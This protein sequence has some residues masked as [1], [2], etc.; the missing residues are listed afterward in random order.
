MRFA[1]CSTAAAMLLAIAKTAS[2]G[3]TPMAREPTLIPAEPLGLAIRTLAK[4]RGFQVVYD[5]GQVTHR[6]TQGASGDLTANEALTEVLRGT[7]LT[8]HKVSNGIVIEP[9]TAHS[10][11]ALPRP[12]ATAHSAPPPAK[13]K[14]SHASPADLGPVTI[15]AARG[16][17]ALR[18]EVDHF[19][20]A[21]VA[22]PSDDGLYRWDRLVCP[23]VAGFPKSAGEFIL[24]RI[25]KAAVDAHAPLAGKVCRPNLYVVSTDS[26][27]QLLESWWARDRQMYDFSLMG[28]EAVKYFIRSRRPI[29]VWY[30]TFRTCWGGFG[31]SPA[32]VGPLRIRPGCAPDTYLVRRG[33]SSNIS[34][35]IVVIDSRRI[36]GMTIQQLADYVALVGLANLR[37]EGGPTPVPSILELFGAGT[38]PKGLTLWDRALLYS[39]YNTSPWQQLQM[40]ELEL[41]MAR[42]IARWPVA[43]SPPQQ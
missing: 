30:N 37:L 33:T 34:S 12:A 31:D 19:A 39:L 22:R 29:R 9:V 32:F 6:R 2:A 38:P 42:Y 14:P 43:W 21:V 24:E 27:D 13:E 40:P 23:L 26:P 10:H 41:T 36:K 5:S 4:E 18:L 35:A 1:I 11:P 15:E 20:T 3:N 8:F 25:S 16:R 17:R 28:I 7:G